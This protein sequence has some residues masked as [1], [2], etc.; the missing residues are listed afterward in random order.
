MSLA[1]ILV[2]TSLL[3]ASARRGLSTTL[4]VVLAVLLNYGLMGAF[5]IPLG[6][7][8]SIFAS[9]ILGVGIDYAIH[10]RSRFDAVCA[11]MGA[12]QAAA[13]TFA[14]SGV[15]IFWDALV[16]G[17]GFMVLAISQMPP[18]RRLGVFVAMGVVSSLVSSFLLTPALF[19][20]GRGRSAHPAGE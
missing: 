13:E 6:V 17:C 9:I 12:E 5:A 19:T 18:V 16:V 20:L 8:T 4:P 1:T 15:A 10:L 11:T 3:F 2:I 7:S 14:S